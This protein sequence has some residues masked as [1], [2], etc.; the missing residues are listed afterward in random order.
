MRLSRALGLALAAGVFAG[1]SG[2]W[3]TFTDVAAEAGLRE[4]VIYGGVETQKYILE[5]TGTGVAVLD[6]DR[7]GLPDIFLVNG[8]RLKLPP[9]EP[10]VHRLYRNA[11]K[12]QFED[13]TAASGLGRSG[14]GQAACVGD[15]DNDGWT[16]LFV[17]S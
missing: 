3:I 7:D 4:P 2:P 5:T 9:G 17:T 6:Y 16:D 14:W 13:V 11:G 10:P 12:G 15:Y 1:G 8:S